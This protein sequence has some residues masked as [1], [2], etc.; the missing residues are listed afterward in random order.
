MIHFS[1]EISMLQ[2]HSPHYKK[3][4]TDEANSFKNS[5]AIVNNENQS[6]TTLVDMNLVDAELILTNEILVITLKNEIVD[7]FIKSIV[8]SYD[9]L[10]GK[11]LTIDEKQT[12]L[13]L[14]YE[15]VDKFMATKNERTESKLRINPIS[16]S[17]YLLLNIFTRT[18]EISFKSILKKKKEH[19]AEYFIRWD[20]YESKSFEQQSENF[21]NNT[22]MF[23]E[24][25][26][27]QKKSLFL[28]EQ[29][30][31]GKITIENW[32]KLNEENNNAIDDLQA[33]LNNNNNI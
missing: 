10:S 7:E 30:E 17:K 26:E 4:I 13:S 8:N 16:N 21:T 3:V 5:D 11:H 2:K 27:L 15:V 1:P 20:I 22:E 25:N 14:I 24:I 32:M 29:L 23:K 9:F 31:K 6:K 12:V 33:K 19:F 28:S 18:K